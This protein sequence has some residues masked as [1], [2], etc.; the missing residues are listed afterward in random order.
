MLHLG[1]REFYGKMP[2][3][4]FE[5]KPFCDQCKS[6]CYNDFRGTITIQNTLNTAIKASRKSFLN[7][8]IDH[9]VKTA[10][11]L[12]SLVAPLAQITFVI[13]QMPISTLFTECKIQTKAFSDILIALSNYHNI[14]HDHLKS[15]NSNW[16]GRDRLHLSDEGNR[17]YWEKIKLDLERLFA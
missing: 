11:E 16:H 10:Y 8:Q 15:K 3:S 13:P 4:Q 14:G 7:Q 17:H 6:S 9:F 5:I 2:A 1:G 12:T